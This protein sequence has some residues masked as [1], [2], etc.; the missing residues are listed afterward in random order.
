MSNVVVTGGYGLIG[1]HLVSALLDRGD[2]VTLFDYAKNTRDTSIDFDRHANFRFVQG[3]VTDL[4]ALE[5]A[6]TPGVDKVFHLAAVVGVK[7][8]MKDPLRVLDVNVTGTR[9]VLELSQRHGTRVIF[10]STS[11]VFGKN[12]NPPWAED[13]DRVLG[14]TRTARWSYSTSKAMAEHLVFAMHTALG[15]PVTVVRYFNVYGPRQNPIFVI[16]QSIHRILNGLQPLL[17]DSGNQTRCFTYVDDAIAG[18]L[19]AGDSDKAIGE[20]YN[21]GSMTETTIGEAVDLAIKIAN[22]DGVSG[23]EAVDTAARYGVRY[24]DIPRRIPDSTKAQRDLGWRLEVDVEE[25][26]R[27][28]IDWAR[29]NPWYLAGPAGD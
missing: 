5:Q 1:T 24:E 13:D 23:A 27:R 21:I 15:L 7:N 14:S 29:A 22:V 26:I 28:T 12:P 18:T 20:A 16:S 8:Y 2:S 3:D 17:Y 11:E 9:N 19:L 10:A 25:G 6:L 4:A